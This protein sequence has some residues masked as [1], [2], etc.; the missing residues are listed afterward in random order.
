M[1]VSVFFPRSLVRVLYSMSIHDTAGLPSD[2]RAT[3][4][5][6]VDTRNTGRTANEDLVDVGLVDLGFR[7]DFRS[8]VQR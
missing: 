2:N 3:L 4:K 8:L 6:F 5:K 7:E 1:E